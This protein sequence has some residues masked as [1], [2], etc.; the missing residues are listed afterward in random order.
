MNI[1][2]VTQY[3]ENV[4]EFAG[5]TGFKCLELFTEYDTALNLDQMTD[6]KI[7]EINSI[8]EKNGVRIGT[9]CCSVNHLDGDPVQRKRNNEYFKKAIRLCKTF[10]ASIVTSNAWADKSRTPLENIPVFKEVFTEYAE[11]AEQE[12]VKIAIEN[13][14]HSI[15]YPMPI[16]NIAFS[17]E[18]WEA[19]FEAVPSKA[20]GLEFDPSHLYWQG[21]DYVKAIR[22]FG[23][24]IYAF[25]AKDTE[26]VKDMQ[27]RC[28]ILGKQFGKASDWDAGWWRYR[29]PGW[30]MID[31][32]GVFKALYDIKFSGPMV[33]EHE[34]PVFD[35]ELREQGLAMGL[36]Y[37]QQFFIE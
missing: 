37:L 35:G 21:I 6:E 18:M 28:G 3:S 5:R 14:P 24:R 26:I 25:H 12:G 2:F 10:G 8:F 36:R 33:I 7:E 29:I 31:W 22:D 27:S 16:G 23:D 32:L 4:V 17:P 11:L 20:V 13:C 15:G 19:L 30:G 9:I 34:D 1:G